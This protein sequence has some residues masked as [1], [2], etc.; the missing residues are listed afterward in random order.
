LSAQESTAKT[1]RS[2]YAQLREKVI[3][4]M[5][6]AQDSSVDRIAL[7]NEEG[8]MLELTHKLEGQAMDDFLASYES[9]GPDK[10]LLLF[11]RAC[12]AMAFTLQ[13]ID[14]FIQTSDRKFLV[15]AKRGIDLMDSV[16]QFF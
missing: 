1:Y 10:S 8:V 5:T 6:R 2:Q 16:E 4:L 7:L 9:R 3:V 14:S 11:A 12:D 13:S 15:L